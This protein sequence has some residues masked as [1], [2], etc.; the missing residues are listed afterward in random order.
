MKTEEEMI[1]NFEENRNILLIKLEKKFIETFKTQEVELPVKYY[2]FGGREAGTYITG[3]RYNPATDKIEYHIQSPLGETWKDESCDEIEYI[4]REKRTVLTVSL[5]CDDIRVTSLDGEELDRIEYR[6]QRY[7]YTRK[8]F[9]HPALMKEIGA[10]EEENIEQENFLFQELKK[11]FLDKFGT[12]EVVFQCSWLYIWEN[13]D[14]IAYVIGIKYDSS[15][16]KFL[17]KFKCSNPEQE[18][19][20]ELKGKDPSI[21]PTISMSNHVLMVALNVKNTYILSLNGEELERMEHFMR[22]NLLDQ[23]ITV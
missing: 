5:K 19:W 10:S 1:K 14:I 3:L 17:Y 13:H 11:R 15:S 6:S 18:V 12:Q 20:E 7:H 16:D 23:E 9:G 2:L 8:I 4:L 21:I 22:N